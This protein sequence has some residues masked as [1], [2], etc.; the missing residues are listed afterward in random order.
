MRTNCR[1]MGCKGMIHIRCKSCDKGTCINHTFEHEW[2][3]PEERLCGK[4]LTEKIGISS[5]GVGVV[6][7]IKCSMCN[8]FTLSGGG[9]SS[10]CKYCSP[11]PS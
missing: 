3:H 9:G 10:V 1:L 5:V 8:F 7:L 4:C 6:K 2:L 11:P